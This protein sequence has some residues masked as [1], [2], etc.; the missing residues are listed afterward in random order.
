[1]ADPVLNWTS[2]AADA[3][4]ATGVPASVLL[5]L[6]KEESGGIEGRTSSAGAEGLTQFMP[7]TAAS[8]GVNTAPGHADSQLLGAGKYLVAL[9][10]NENPDLA[11][12]KYNAG[13]AASSAV[14]NSS[15]VAAYAKNVLTYAKSYTAY[16]GGGAGTS[17]ASTSAASSSS[18]SL[19]DSGQHS[20]L[21]RVGLTAGLVVAGVGAIVAGGARAAGAGAKA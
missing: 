8:Y 16:D 4:R 10:F 7:G 3:E 13:P 18:S 21:V 17:P 1:M 6:V 9:G 2:Q 19:I 5:G 12:R 11:L 15:A 20:T 14:L